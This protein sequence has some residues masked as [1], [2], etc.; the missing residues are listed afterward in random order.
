MNASDVFGKY[1]I[2]DRTGQEQNENKAGPGFRLGFAGRRWAMKARPPRSAESG[3]RHRRNSDVPDQDQRKN[4]RFLL[5]SL[6][7]LTLA[8]AVIGTVTVFAVDIASLYQPSAP[9][10]SYVYPHLFR[11]R[12]HYLTGV[13]T[14]LLNMAQA[15]FWAGI[16]LFFVFAIASEW[17]KYRTDKRLAT[18]AHEADKR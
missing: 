10:G 3:Q 4:W 17:L 1:I 11:G 13:Q 6:M 14:G 12:L 16:G 9:L 15:A 18:R 7:V 2:A 5:L 8:M